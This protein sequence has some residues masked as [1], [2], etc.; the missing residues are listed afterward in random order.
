MDYQTYPPTSD[1]SSLVKCFWTLEIPR[2]L[3]FPRQRIIPDGC[4]EMAFI[5]G[6]DIKRYTNETDFILQPRACVIGHTTDPF[7]IEPTGSVKTF[8]IRF[9]PYGIT[10]FVD[11]SLESLANKETPLDQIFGFN[12]A[13]ELE[14][15][16]IQSVN[17]VT[18]IQIIEEFLL[19]Q[20][21]KNS[22]IDSIVRR[23]IDVILETKGSVSIGS[24][25]L[26]DV[27]KRKQLERK[28]LKEVGVTPKKL[29]K[30]IRLQTALT[31]LL[32]A[33]STNL[34]QIAY[35][36]DY[37][38]QAHFIKDFKEFTGLNPKKFLKDKGMI[39]STLFYK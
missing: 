1:L 12:I 2:A 30:M 13:K 31:M 29:G 26:D 4:V 36:S 21:K 33:E 34:I 5:L 11:I 35:E 32:N 16:I 27:T 38:D 10:N 23:T 6:D 24:L 39:L 25:V 17:T 15:K 28:F 7:Y 8:A 3:E 20:L 37:F 18:R 22:T 19:K 14:E 9:Y